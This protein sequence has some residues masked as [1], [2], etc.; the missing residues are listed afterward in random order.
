MKTMWAFAVF[1]ICALAGKDALQAPANTRIWPGGGVRLE[2]HN[3]TIEDKGD[4]VYVQTGKCRPN[5]W[6]NVSF[7]YDKPADLSMARAVKMTFTNA[8][9]RSLRISIKVK[10]RTVQGRLPEG[11]CHVPA[12]GARTYSLRLFSEG[13]IFDKD[14]K[15]LGLKRKPNV[16]HG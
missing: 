6:P 3:A 4:I 16:G 14:P 1:A 10:G 13:W 11:G 7:V 15:L 12:W 8:T 2:G 5:T 9:D